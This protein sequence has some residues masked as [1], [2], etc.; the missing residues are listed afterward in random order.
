MFRV[1]IYFAKE[2]KTE[3]HML[4]T[5]VLKATPLKVK[6]LSV[7]LQL[8]WNTYHYSAG[9]AHLRNAKWCE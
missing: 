8:K 1:D 3:M 7:H 2:K 4:Q 9:G 6:V 5:T